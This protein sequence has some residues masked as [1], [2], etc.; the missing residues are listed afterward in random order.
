MAATKILFT[1]YYHQ[2]IIVFFG[3]VATMSGGMGNFNQTPQGVWTKCKGNSEHLQVGLKWKSG[4][5]EF[6]ALMRMLD[7]KVII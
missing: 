2:T 4:E 6:E 3:Q 1:G 5:L 7:N